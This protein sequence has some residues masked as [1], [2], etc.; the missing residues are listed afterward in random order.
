MVNK[1]LGFGLALVLALALVTI[2]FAAVTFD[3]ESGEGF[4]G[5][6]DVQLVFGWNN[7]AL[8]DNADSV[9]FRV[10]SESETTWTCSRA[11]PQEQTRNRHNTTTTQGVVAKVDRV[12][13]QINGFI[14]DGFDG[15]PTISTDGHAPQSCGGGG[16]TYDEGSEQTTAGDGGLQV[17]IDGIVW[18]D[19]DTTE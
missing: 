12:R 19:L 5:K 15:E 14:L 6:G 13:N 1:T 18:Y 4:V 7:K 10:S 17:S 8:Q 2:A 11:E 16:F 3:A 9:Q